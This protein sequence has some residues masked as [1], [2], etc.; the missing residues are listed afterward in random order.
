MGRAGVK[1]DKEHL[2]G[3]ADGDCPVS[4]FSFVRGSEPDW[5]GYRE[6]G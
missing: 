2:R 5:G 3:S 6:L 1:V 4:R